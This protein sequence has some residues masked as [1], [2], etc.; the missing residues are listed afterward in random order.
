MDG[1]GVETATI[2]AGDTVGLGV[3]LASVSF[4]STKGEKGPYETRN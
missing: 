3:Y 1:A 4:P 2:I